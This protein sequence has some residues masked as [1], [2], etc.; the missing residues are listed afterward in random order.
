VFFCADR[1][2]AGCGGRMEQV[3]NKNASLFTKLGGFYKMKQGIIRS[4]NEEK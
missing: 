1:P 4:N 3:V 2:A